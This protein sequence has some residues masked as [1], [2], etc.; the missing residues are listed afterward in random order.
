MTSKT[1]SVVCLFVVCD[2]VS[3]W[4]PD[5]FPRTQYVV[6]TGLKLEAK[7]Q[8]QETLVQVLD[9]QGDP[10]KKCY[11]FFGFRDEETVP[12]RFHQ[13]PSVMELTDIKDRLSGCLTII[14]RSLNLVCSLNLA[15]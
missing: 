1:V 7:L 15:N 5:F 13:H 14:R 4:T 6:H 8:I 12:G 10:P 9:A 3:Y 11:S 2:R